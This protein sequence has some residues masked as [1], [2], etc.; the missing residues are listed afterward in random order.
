VPRIRLDR[1]SLEAHSTALPKRDQEIQIGEAKYRVVEQGL[2][3]IVVKP[4]LLK[5]H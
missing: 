5:A 2:G 1:C 3:F 4:Q